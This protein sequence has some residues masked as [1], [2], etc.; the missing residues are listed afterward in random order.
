MKTHSGM[1]S[2][3]FGKKR[4]IKLKL[5]HSSFMSFFTCFKQVVAGLITVQTIGKVTR[6]NPKI[7]VIIFWLECLANQFVYTLKIRANPPKVKVVTPLI[8]CM[9]LLIRGLM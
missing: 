4:L 1:L 6:T 9:N 3:K 8:M 2:T 5:N 7:N